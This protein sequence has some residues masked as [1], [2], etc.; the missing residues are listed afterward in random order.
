MVRRLTHTDCFMLLQFRKLTRGAAATLILGLVGIAMVIFLIPQT[1]LSNLGSANLAEVSGR[2]VTPVQLARE[3]EL[4]LRSRRNQGENISQEEAVAAGLHTR[5]LDSMIA[6]NALY[7]YAEKRGVSASDTQVA[8][9]IRDIPSVLNPVS[10]Q[11]DETAYAQFLNQMRYSRSEFEADI[12]DDLSTQL[13][14]SGLVSGV[15]APSSYGALV[16]AYETETRVISIAE[17]PA[18]AVGNVAPPTEAQLQAFYEE[19]QERLRVPEFRALTIVY[20]R[21]EDFIARIN[22]PEARLQEEFEAR[23]ASLTQPERRSYV[24]ISAQTQQQANDAVARLTRG[25]SPDAVASALGL[26]ITRGANQARTEVPD[27]RVAAAVFEQPRGQARAIQGQLTPWAVVRVEEITPASEPT[28]ASMRAEL[29]NA[30]ASEEAADLLNTAIGAFDDARAAGASVTDA[31]RQAN[32]PVVTIPAVSADGRAQTGEP[33]AA[34]EGQEA[35]LQIAFETP[36]SEASDFLPVGD[37]DVVVA[38]D[39]IIPASVRPL[40]EVREDLSRFWI[41]R[42]RARRLRELGAEFIAAV[43]GGQDFRAVARAR[44]FT[45][46]VNSQR[47]NREAAAEIPARGLPAQIFAAAQNDVVSDMR[48]DGGAILVA[49]VEEIRREDPASAPQ[50]VEAARGQLEQ[51]LVASLGQA[52]QDEVVANAR[53]RRN[54][55]LLQ[56][57]YPSTSADAEGQ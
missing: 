31:A 40:A 28:F 15:R 43:E 36:E 54:D 57:L 56:Q 3:L 24:R 30:I 4:T 12:R 13:L 53:P 17:A 23:R 38:V 46:R 1:G 18:S 48:A 26:Q 34:L 10:G 5:L 7:A 2:K 29:H 11:F 33:V 16:F 39:R 45:I 21:P 9:Y 41:I 6:R 19:S 25:E 20:A 27:A 35:L 22:V 14:M 55:R 52:A 50:V 44:G 37:A 51:A 47:I 42:E 32:L 49:R 8:N